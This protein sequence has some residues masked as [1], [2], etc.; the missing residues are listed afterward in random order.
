MQVLFVITFLHVC[1]SPIT[2][3]F[4]Q[5]FSKLNLSDYM[6]YYMLSIIAFYLLFVSHSLSK[7][8]FKS[9]RNVWAGNHP[10]S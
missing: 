2:V 4:I 10:V 1:I 7:A 3:F 5:I 6:Q 8:F 9:H